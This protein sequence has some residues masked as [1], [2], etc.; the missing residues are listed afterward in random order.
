MDNRTEKLL[1][2]LDAS[3]SVYHAAKNIEDELKN[4]G[5]TRISEA[6]KWE[7][8]PGGKYYLTRGGSAVLAFRIPEGEPSGFMMSASHSDRPAPARC[9]SDRPYQG[10]YSPDV[11]VPGREERAFPETRQSLRCNQQE[12]RSYHHSAWIQSAI[13]SPGWQKVSGSNGAKTEVRIK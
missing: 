1:N 9:G 4:A 10:R 12:V 6:E 3:P 5:Y 2:F 8:V 13:R 7:L 11:S